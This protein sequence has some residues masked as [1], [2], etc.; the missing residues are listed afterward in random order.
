M[1]TEDR[2]IALYINELNYKYLC[3]FVNNSIN[4][5]NDVIHYSDTRTVFRY[6]MAG[7]RDDV[8]QED[9]TNI[10]CVNTPLFLAELGNGRKFVG[11]VIEM[12][13]ISAKAIE[14]LSS[15]ISSYD[16]IN[17]SDEDRKYL[18]KP[19]LNYKC[20]EA[21]SI[22]LAFGIKINKETMNKMPKYEINCAVSLYTN[23]TYTP[24]IFNNFRYEAINDYE[25][26]NFIVKMIGQ[27]IVTGTVPSLDITDTNID[28]GLLERSYAINYEIPA[29]NCDEIKEFIEHSNKA[30]RRSLTRDTH[31]YLELAAELSSNN[32]HK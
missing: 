7:L 17:I 18:Y 12:D 11:N 32:K 5:D 1:F 31:K 23:N 25:A 10:L 20:S 6:R 15:L 16:D 22:V 21:N 24:L 9:F 13:V 14:I 3:G 2:M 4:R 19:V 26:V 30:I 8:N 29:H 28:M 27:Y